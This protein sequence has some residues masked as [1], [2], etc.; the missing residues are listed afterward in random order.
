MPG[1][2]FLVTLPEILKSCSRAP[3]FVTLKVTTPFADDFF[4]SVNL[5]SDGLPAVT[6]TTVAFE[7]P[8]ATGSAIARATAMLA[9]IAINPLLV[10]LLLGWTVPL[11]GHYACGHTP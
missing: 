2:S 6:F 10:M 5:S 7:A 3:L 8:A 4:D 1:F 9:R 11:P